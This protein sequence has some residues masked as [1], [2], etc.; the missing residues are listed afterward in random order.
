VEAAKDVQHLQGQAAKADKVADE[1]ENAVGGVDEDLRMRILARQV[2]ARYNEALYH[3]ALLLVTLERAT[4][5]GFCAG[6]G[7][8]A[9]TPPAQD[10]PEPRLPPP[11]PAR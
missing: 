9:S 10:K 4:G 5:G 3:H 2:E 1:V 11:A 7:Y 8:T 6:F